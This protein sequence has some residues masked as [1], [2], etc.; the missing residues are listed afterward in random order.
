MGAALD[1]PDLPCMLRFV[2]SSSLRVSVLLG[3]ALCERICSLVFSDVNV[4]AC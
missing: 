2:V 3:S 4:G 1:S